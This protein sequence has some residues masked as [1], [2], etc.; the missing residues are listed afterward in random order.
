MQT[1][2]QRQ[3]ML[4]RQYPIHPQHFANWGTSKLLSTTSRCLIMPRREVVEGRNSAT[5]FI[6]C[7]QSIAS[8]LPQ[9]CHEMLRMYAPLIES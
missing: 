9:K 8:Q 5:V 1:V 2:M 4:K 3:H 6:G 7:S